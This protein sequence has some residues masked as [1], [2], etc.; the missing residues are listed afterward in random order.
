MKMKFDDI[1]NRHSGSTA[2]ILGLGPS[3][4]INHDKYR[5]LSKE[6]GNIFFSCNHAYNYIPAIELDYLITANS[7]FTVKNQHAYFNQGGKTLLWADTVDDTS[8]DEANRLLTIDWLNYAER[9]K[10][11]VQNKVREYCNSPVHLSAP[12]TVVGSIICFAILMG[13]TDI[14]IDGLDLDYGKGYCNGHEIGREQG[15]N[16]LVSIQHSMSDYIKNIELIAKNKGINITFK[17]NYAWLN[18]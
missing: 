11:S 18:R 1:I 12:G 6:E 10:D 8:L 16:A 17:H 5:A 4:D 2:Y 15:A 7:V 14:Y 3:L 13:C 9:G